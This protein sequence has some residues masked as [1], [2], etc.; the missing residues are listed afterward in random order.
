MC[1]LDKKPCSPELTD[2]EIT[3]QDGLRTTK[4]TP[5]WEPDKREP[6]SPRR[7]RVTVKTTLKLDRKCKICCLKGLVLTP[8]LCISLR[9]R[10]AVSSCLWC[11]K[12]LHFSM[13]SE[14][15]NPALRFCWKSRVTAVVCKSGYTV[16]DQRKSWGQILQRVKSQKEMIC[17]ENVRLATT[18][19]RSCLGPK[20]HRPPASA[21]GRTKNKNQKTLD[22]KW[23]DKSSLRSAFLF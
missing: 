6:D 12:P 7:P 5:A 9:W 8:D 11:L 3:C 4:K 13:A 20:I 2:L 18:F 19:F 14:G 1:V 21:K 10:V 23:R 15:V 22:S 16:W 17:E